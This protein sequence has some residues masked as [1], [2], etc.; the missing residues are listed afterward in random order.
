VSDDQTQRLSGEEFFYDNSLEYDRTAAAVDAVVRN[1]KA[2]VR[3]GFGDSLFSAWPK[4][5]ASQ[6]SS[7]HA[8]A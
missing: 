5:G 4:H 7:R 3:D 8:S 2:F 1:W 6:F